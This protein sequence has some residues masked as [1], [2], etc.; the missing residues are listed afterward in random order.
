MM[1]D[2]STSETSVSFYQIPRR[3]NSEDSNSHCENLKAY[4]RNKFKN[5]CFTCVCTDAQVF[6]LMFDHLSSFC[7]HDVSF[8][9]AGY[10]VMC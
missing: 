1:E 9:S 10:V 6:H 3:Y 7:P 2:A 4:I 5:S 8:I